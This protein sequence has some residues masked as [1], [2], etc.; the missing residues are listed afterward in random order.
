MPRPVARKLKFDK[1]DSADNSD[2]SSSLIFI[3]GDSDDNKDEM[4]IE[5]KSEAEDV[6]TT[7]DCFKM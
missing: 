2:D 4:A 1:T 3:E 7:T 5:V 6:D